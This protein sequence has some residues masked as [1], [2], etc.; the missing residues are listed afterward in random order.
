MITTPGQLNR[1]AELYHQLGSM[2]GA[3]VP[4]IKSL[5]MVRSS[6]AIGVSRTTVDGL[7][8]YL[9]AG[10]TFTESM[11]RIQ[12]WMPDFDI[13]LLAVGEESGKLD[14]SFKLLA[15]HYA[16]RA[17][18]I[19]DTIAG[20]ITTMATLHV[21]LLI[22]PL[23]LLIAFVQGIVFGDLSRCLPFLIE[24]IVVFGG[25]YSGAFLLIY[26]MQGQRGEVW[27]S[28]VETVTQVIPVLGRARWFL[29]LSR[30]AGAL[31]AATAAGVSI[32]KSWELAGAASGSPQLRR[33]INTWRPRLEAGMTP[34]E[35]I[36]QSNCFPQIFANRYETAEQS[37][38]IDEAL[39]R[40]QMYYQEEGFRAL[41][42][43]TRLMNGTIYGILV[44][45][46]AYTVV[47][48]Y[49]GYFSQ[50]WTF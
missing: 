8:H 33:E 24:K 44:L 19:R 17:S 14:G 36:N 9:Q 30:L 38:R 22:F 49:I 34:A 46:V 40:L 32:F 10:L 31:E 4:L 41:R 42:L 1:R 45:V 2:V 50:M 13:A 37:G 25:I 11:Q 15:E 21:F 35:L 28:M 27:R 6:P 26:A 43:F 7:I 12:G 23:S 48:F 16:A 29:A 5:E 39:H 20:L 18:I 3:G 47:T